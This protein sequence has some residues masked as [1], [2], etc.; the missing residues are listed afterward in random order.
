MKYGNIKIN[1]L[2]NQWRNCACS[3]SSRVILSRLGVWCV[4]K[5][6][7]TELKAWNAFPTARRFEKLLWGSPETQCHEV[8]CLLQTMRR[9]HYAVGLMRS[10]AY[11]LFYVMCQF[12]YEL[13][14]YENCYFRF[15]IHVL[16]KIKFV[17]VLIQAPKTKFNRNLLM[18]FGD[19]AFRRM[20]GRT[21]KT[22]H[23]FLLRTLWNECLRFWRR[24]CHSSGG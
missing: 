1:P 7:F 17:H 14:F 11:K 18:R 19:E 4:E 22:P 2:R 21:D 8:L 20:N 10:R 13:M 12:C 16:T 15:E 23:A 9:S 3:G 24:S 6:L 5:K